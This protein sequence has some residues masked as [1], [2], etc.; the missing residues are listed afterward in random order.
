MVRETSTWTAKPK[1]I[2]EE[3]NYEE[4]LVKL[5]SSANLELLSQIIS[6]E[7]RDYHK[8][9]VKGNYNLTDFII[10][11]AIKTPLEKANRNQLLAYLQLIS[12][13]FIA[14]N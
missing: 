11:H 5:F 2:S 14:L 10:T 13:Y 4:T 1:I 12:P 3:E 9:I 8:A 6:E 7:N